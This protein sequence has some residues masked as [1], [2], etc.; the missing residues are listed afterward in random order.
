MCLF[1]F[2]ET[3]RLEKKYLSL[4]Q[5]LREFSEFVF[6]I[7]YLR[8]LVSQTN[9]VVYNIYIFYLSFLCAFSRSISYS[10]NN[11]KET[12]VKKISFSY[13][14]DIKKKNEKNSGNIG[15]QAMHETFFLP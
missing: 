4:L 13:S 7:F 14:N 12:Q 1:L 8:I 6:I 10:K 3:C 2:Q 5:S 9:K 15:L 11:I